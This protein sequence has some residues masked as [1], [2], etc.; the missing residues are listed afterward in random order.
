MPAVNASMLISDI[1]SSGKTL[2]ENNLRPLTDGE[3]LKS[4]ACIFSSK[5]SLK[6]KGVKSLIK[7]LSKD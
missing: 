2:F 7:L 6:K 5:K 3:I 1:S 4:Q